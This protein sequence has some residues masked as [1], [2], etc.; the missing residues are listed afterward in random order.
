M[1]AS[2]LPEALGPFDSVFKRTEFLQQ[3]KLKP[4]S[5]W[6]EHMKL[7]SEQ[8]EQCDRLLETGESLGQRLKLPVVKWGL[9]EDS[10]D[11]YSDPHKEPDDVRESMKDRLPKNLIYLKKSR[12]IYVKEK[13]LF[14]LVLKRKEARQGLEAA[15]LQL[16]EW[17]SKTA[18]LELYYAQMMATRH[19]EN[20]KEAL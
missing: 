19:E 14:D 3:L 13:E 4:P 17:E 11:T 8:I 6:L 15:N 16:Q 2:N 7:L 10:Q 9:G 18:D 1:A 12:E 20:E 5:V